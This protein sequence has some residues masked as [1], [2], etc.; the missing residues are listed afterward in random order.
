MAP[1]RETVVLAAI[2][3]RCKIDLAAC[4]PG[5]VRCPRCGTE[6][7]F[8]VEVAPAAPRSEPLVKPIEPCAIAIEA[9]QAMIDCPVCQLSMLDRPQLRADEDGLEALWCPCGA[10]RLNGRWYTPLASKGP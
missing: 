4:V 8:R 7:D 1:G 3:F 2:C 5:A 10:V 6:Y 9:W